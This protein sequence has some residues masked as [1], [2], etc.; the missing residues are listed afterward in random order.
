MARSR[1][2]AVADRTD[3]KLDAREA[4]DTRRTP[5]SLAARESR[6]GRL[7]HW[8]GKGD[9]GGWD[10]CDQ[11]RATAQ[12]QGSLRLLARRV[13]RSEERRVGKE[14]RSRWARYH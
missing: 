10:Y 13:L 11:V 5:M 8:T 1:R 4:A 3:P 12:C 7:P 9:G 2:T 14:C 6:A